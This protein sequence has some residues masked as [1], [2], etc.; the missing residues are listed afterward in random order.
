MPFPG[1]PKGTKNSCRLINIRCSNEL[2]GVR[3]IS[4]HATTTHLN[5]AKRISTKAKN[6]CASSWTKPARRVWPG[7]ISA[8]CP[9]T[10]GPV[11]NRLASQDSKFRNGKLA[12]E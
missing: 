12:M 7:K 2:A 9:I 5:T 6:T 1:G 8:W 3:R 11:C 10:C 4:F